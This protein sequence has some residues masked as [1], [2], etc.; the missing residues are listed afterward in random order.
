MTLAFAPRTTDAFLD[1]CKVADVLVVVHYAGSNIDLWAESALSSA[2]AQGAPS[3]VGVLQ[4]LRSTAPKKHAGIKKD[5]NK[6][7]KKNF[8]GDSTCKGFDSDAATERVAFARHVSSLKPRDVSWRGANPH[9]L[10]DR[11]DYDAASGTLRASGYLRAR[12]LAVEQLVH[13]VGG[14]T[15][16]LS[17]MQLSGGPCPPEGMSGRYKTR[18]GETAGDMSTEDGGAAVS[19]LPDE[20]RQHP[21]AL[22]QPAGS[23]A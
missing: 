16:Q 7:L 17:Q 2:R 5:F 15:Y 4:N 23:P 18:D 22:E 21:L 14:G 9:L 13:V 19:V 12:G 8:A 3:V 1:L 10:V 11:V 20:A 6:F